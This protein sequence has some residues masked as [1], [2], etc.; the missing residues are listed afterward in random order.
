MSLLVRIAILLLWSVAAIG[1]AAAR[2]PEAA[3]AELREDSR[4]ALARLYA[5]QPE[6]RA[7]VEGAAGYATFSTLGIKL[8]AGGTGKGRGLAVAR[9][10][11]E[12]FMRF[13][14]VQ[15]GLGVGIKKHDL[16]FVFDAPQALAAFLD[17]G[18]ETGGQATLAAKANGKGKAYQGA[19]SV[20]EG[21]WLYQVT[22]A[23]L[24]A[25]VTLKGSKYFRDAKLN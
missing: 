18:W 15:A 21:V 6:A 19:V 16:V 3:R 10:G 1:N 14:E 22:Q 17:K 13:V 8:G 24:S 2:D 25:E 5:A 7:A 9:E 12:T 23:G 11:Q 4:A 20:S